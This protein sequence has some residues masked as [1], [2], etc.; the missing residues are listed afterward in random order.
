MVWSTSALPWNG[1]LPGVGGGR[2]NVSC[3]MFWQQKPP[4][5]A[6]V[7][8]YVDLPPWTNYS[9]PS[10]WGVAHGLGNKRVA[11]D[12]VSSARGQLSTPTMP[13]CRIDKLRS[14]WQKKGQKGEWR[15]ILKQDNIL[16]FS[17]GTQNCWIRRILCLH[18]TWIPSIINRGTVCPP[19]PKKYYT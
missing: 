3:P 7:N 5:I 14:G 10:G 1:R 19:I 15:Q 12:R 4:Q 17:F 11:S 9:N 18:L 8:C 2:G 6:P 13:R 16:A